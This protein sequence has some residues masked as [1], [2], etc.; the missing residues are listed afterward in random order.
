M[1]LVGSILSKLQNRGWDIGTSDIGTNDIGINDIRTSDNGI[2]DIRAGDI[3]ASP[4]W[5]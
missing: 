2:N 4:H 3:G 5:D 1:E